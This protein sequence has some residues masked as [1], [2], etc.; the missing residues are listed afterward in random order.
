MGWGGKKLLTGVKNLSPMKRKRFTKYLHTNVLLTFE[1]ITRCY[2]GSITQ[3]NRRNQETHFSTYLSLILIEMGDSWLFIVSKIEDFLIR[4]HR[5]YE[6]QVYIWRNF[7]G[8]ICARVLSEF[9][10]WIPNQWTSF[11]IFQGKKTWYS[12]TLTIWVQMVGGVVTIVVVTSCEIFS[13]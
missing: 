6:S 7:L 5:W 3:N 10:I 9:K 13:F 1:E 12:F 2:I 4:V 8:K 11:S